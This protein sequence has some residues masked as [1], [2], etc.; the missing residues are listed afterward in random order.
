MNN[1]T[2]KYAITEALLNN[3]DIDEKIGNGIA[4]FLISSKKEYSD[5][6]H[7][8]VDYVKS[9]LKPTNYYD[10]KCVLLYN[11]LSGI[12]NNDTKNF[13]DDFD[14]YELIQKIEESGD[15]T[16]LSRNKYKDGYMLFNAILNKIKTRDTKLCDK[17]LK[18]LTEKDNAIDIIELLDNAIKVNNGEELKILFKD[19][20]NLVPINRGI[21]I[22]AYAFG[23][24][25]KS[26]FNN[27]KKKVEKAVDNI[28][29]GLKKAKDEVVKLADQAGNKISQAY[30]GS[31]VED[32]VQRTGQLVGKAYDGLK[33]V[34]SNVDGIVKNS[35]TKFVEK[36]G[37]DNF[38]GKLA[39][40]IANY[41]KNNEDINKIKDANYFSAY[42]G[43]KVVKD[44]LLDGIN[45]NILS[46][47]NDTID[48]INKDKD[49][50]AKP[51]N[52]NIGST[53]GIGDFIVLGQNAGMI[54]QK[55]DMNTY[56]KDIQHEYGHTL[57]Y[58][59]MGPIKYIKDVA[60][61]SMKGYTEIDDTVKYYSQPW[62][63]GADKLGKVNREISYEEGSYPLGDNTNEK[64]LYVKKKRF[65]KNIADWLDGLN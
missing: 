15:E 35:A 60:I 50:D 62:E 41:D 43:K 3:N 54:N 11:I 63:R 56:K 59:N 52:I 57:Q 34:K 20:E 36:Y 18:A 23:D 40:D 21:P 19:C 44:K 49:K 51:S 28:G 48:K 16:L 46:V 37:D 64:S 1:L 12:L 32:A 4:E 8:I 53:F 30:K 33:E 7:V 14:N 25:L 58:D 29:N 65:I 42:K 13:S 9:I 39:E 26:F 24:K 10:K 31:V 17:C 5:I 47:V 6:D 27:T 22:G 55:F 45:N 38:F 61:P 2:N